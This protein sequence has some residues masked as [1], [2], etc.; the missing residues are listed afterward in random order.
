MKKIVV[1]AFA[2]VALAACAP[3]TTSSPAVTVTQTQS[4]PEPVQ[5]MSLDEKVVDVAR[6]QGNSYIANLSDSAILEI[7]G[8][9]CQILDSGVTVR[10]L[11]TELA[12]SLANDGVTDPEQFRAVGTLLGVAVAAYCPQ[13]ESQV[14]SI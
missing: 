12:K 9:V 3:S 11:V 5:T 2:V 1:V 10:Q 4:A 8:Q 6:S 13:Y 14:Q 7:T